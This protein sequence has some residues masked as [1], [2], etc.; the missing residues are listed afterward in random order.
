[1]ESLTG[2]TPKDNR[3]EWVKQIGFFKD[4]CNKELKVIADFD[5]SIADMKRAAANDEEADA[6]A[7]A[8]DN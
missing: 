8:A 2:I 3:N 7:S 1:M 6:K 5:N 4:N